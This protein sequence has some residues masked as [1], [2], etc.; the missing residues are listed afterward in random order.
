M[1]IH[2]VGGGV[3]GLF[4]GYILAREGYEVAVYEKCRRLGCGA[5]GHNAGV[6]HVIQT[7]FNSLKTRLMRIGLQIY[8]EEADW[9]EPRWTR[10]LIPYRAIP[11]GAK[12]SLVAWILRRNGVEARITRE[13]HRVEP[14][15]N[16]AFDR[17]IIVD[18]YG[19][20][21]PRTLLTRLM[22][23]AMEEGAEVRMGE[24]HVTCGDA[25][26]IYATGVENYVIG[27]MIGDDPPRHRLSLGVMVRIGL[28]TE[29]ILAPLPDI[30]RRYTKGGAIIPH[31]GYSIMGP[32]FAWLDEEPNPRR[33]AHRIY[34]RFLP[35]L[36]GEPEPLCIDSGVRP[37]NMPRDDYI[38]RRVGRDIILYGIDS[39]GLTAAP[40]IARL[41]SIM[42]STDMDVEDALERLE[43]TYSVRP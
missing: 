19:V 29:N 10:L 27:R 8:R 18:G 40:A 12:A 24:E 16:R 35:L 4:T 30:R 31:R 42:L 23:R 7:P 32:G 41:I 25:V 20:V 33:E 43:K 3:V 14:A 13:P 5:S 9:A 36:H 2:V 17:A 38:I 26:H 1:E 11:S 34:R 21:E 39:P 22:E 28:E 37:I 6:L 15:L